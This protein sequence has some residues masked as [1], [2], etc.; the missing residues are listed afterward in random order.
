MQLSVSRAFG[1]PGGSPKRRTSLFAAFAVVASLVPVGLALAPSAAHA[2]AGD[3]VGVGFKLEG[4]RLNGVWTDGNLLSGWNEL[5]LVPYRITATAGNSA[6]SPSQTYKVVIATDY[7][8]GGF[9]GYDDITDPSADSGCT[10]VSALPTEPGQVQDPGQGGAD[11]TLYR[12]LTVTQA[13]NTTC[14]ISFKARLAVGSHNYPGS[15]LHVNLENQSLGTAGIGSKEVSIPVNGIQPQVL[16]PNQTAVAGTT[17]SWLVWKTSDSPNGD[18]ANTCDTNAAQLSTNVNITV[19]WQKGAAAP[20]GQV[21]ITTQITATNPAHRA[22]TVDA[23]DV[24]TYGPNVAD[25]YTI[26]TGPV[27][28]A[29]GATVPLLTTPDVHDVTTSNTSIHNSLS[30]T[31]TDLLTGVPVPGTAASTFDTPVTTTGGTDTNASADILDKEWMTGS[32]LTFSVATPASGS[33]VEDPV[34]HDPA[35]TA[36][37]HT[38]GPVWWDSGTVSDSGSITF[39]KTVYVSSATIT[40]GHLYDD[41]ALT[42]SDGFSA[43]SGQFDFPVTAEAA[44]TANIA[45]SMNKTFITSKTFT[46]RLTDSVGNE[47]S[48]KTATVSIP[49]GSSTGT[50]TTVGGLDTTASYL[51]NED[52]TAPFAPQTGIGPVTWTLVPGSPASCLNTQ[53]VQNTALGP[54]VEVA[55][56]TNPGSGTSWSFSLSG[57]DINSGSG[58]TL[59]VTATAVGSPTYVAFSNRPG[60]DGAT[61]T[62]TETKQSGWDLTD[63]TGD[64]AT[65]SSRVLKDK[66][67]GT[68]TF[69]L[70]LSTDANQ[71]I[72]CAFTNTQR[73][74]I[75]IHKTESGAPITGSDAFTFQLRSGASSAS[76]GSTLDTEV[77][78]AA[79]GGNFQFSVSSSTL[80]VPG[81]YQVCEFVAVGWKSTIQGMAGAFVPGSSSTPDI[82]NS[83]I[84]API[85]LNP[86]QDFSLNVDNTPPPG[87]MAK[88]IGFWKNWASCTTSS[89]KKA[90]TLDQTMALA[91]PG[92]ILI[93]TLTLHGSTATPNNAPDCLSAVRLLNKSTISS[94]T[95]RASDPAFNNVAQLLAY[96]LNILAGAGDKPAAND[97]A[98]QSQAILAAVGFNGN[99]HAALTPAQA[100]ALNTYA[101]TLDKYNNNTL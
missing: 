40:S 13:P 94:G 90:H 5:D 45:K 92:G 47:I 98:T 30:A 21:E 61:Y 82:D 19:H 70:N 46:F 89:T 83:Y 2:S 80:L 32:N 69:T 77:A 48:G 3:P 35:Y 25:T 41:A 17:H 95:K 93:G 34:T 53:S 27:D 42:G 11:K 1:R 67:A 39:A 79:N 14:V 55:K 85:T 20:S 28:V 8:S 59:P 99:T 38:T 6:T 54:L 96:R 72:K 10:L 81:T 87:G 84:C 33:F 65:D 86:G 60:T 12:T 4:Q 97:A 43:D 76:Q 57:P 51:W 16:T 74:T 100:A 49:I 9:F 58:E 63:I 62:I 64:V 18:F 101:T 71:V 68:C 56:M 91:E 15:S 23:V 26:D 73:G 37:T 7:E 75:T 52:A 88:T 31:Y 44:G 66:A 29:A 50:S 24:V 36:G 22:I 78:N